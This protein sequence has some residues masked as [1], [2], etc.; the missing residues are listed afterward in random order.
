MKTK[1]LKMALNILPLLATHTVRPRIV[2]PKTK[3]SEIPSLG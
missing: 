1:K 3:T 2:G